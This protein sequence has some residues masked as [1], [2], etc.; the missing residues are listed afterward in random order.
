MSNMPSVPEPDKTSVLNLDYKT[1][2][3][4]SY[5]P[6][7]GA[8]LILSVVWLCTE[9]KS[10]SK[11]RFYAMQQAILSGAFIAV[12]IIVGISSFMLAMIPIIGA[13]AGLFGLAWMIA[14][15]A[16]VLANVYGMYQLY[17]GNEFRIPYIA[18]MAEQYS[19]K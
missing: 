13:L 15:G 16:Y 7:C 17:Q 9:P 6:V 2:A 19:S 18:D 1:A 12:G 10:N 5:L 14:V 4:L 11:L 8:N 3:I